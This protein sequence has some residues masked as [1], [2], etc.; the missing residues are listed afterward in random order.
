M[1]SAF[2]S[3]IA[4]RK[5]RLDYTIGISLAMGMMDKFVDFTNSAN[6]MVRYIVM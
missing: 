4:D 1:G 2:D 3:V 5:A 6:V